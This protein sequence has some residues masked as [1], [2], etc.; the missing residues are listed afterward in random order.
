MHR[1]TKSCLSRKVTTFGYKKSNSVFAHSSA[2]LLLV[3]TAFD[4]ATGDAYCSLAM[5]PTS[6]WAAARDKSKSACPESNSYKP[7]EKNKNGHSLVLISETK[8]PVASIFENKYVCAG[9]MLKKKIDRLNKV[10]VLLASGILVWSF[11]GEDFLSAVPPHYPV[12]R[13]EGM[14]FSVLRMRCPFCSPFAARL[15]SNAPRYFELKIGVYVRCPL[16][17]K[18]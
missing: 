1:H 14:G 18:P 10:A 8:H 13:W 7:K 6:Q 11:N 15:E 9:Q 16:D 17:E 5:N 12:F 3:S 2:L 4:S